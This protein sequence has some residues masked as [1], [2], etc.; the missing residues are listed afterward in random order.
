[1]RIPEGNVM[2]EDEQDM[3]EAAE[4]QQQQEEAQQL[5]NSGVM[6]PRCFTRPIPLWPRPN[7]NLRAEL[8]A[9][10]QRIVDLVHGSIQQKP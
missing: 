6:D 5:E 3:Q 1:M 9:Y 10:T 2:N 7:S 4:H 8:D